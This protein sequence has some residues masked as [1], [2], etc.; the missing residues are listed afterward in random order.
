VI[1]PIKGH[2]RSNKRVLYFPQKSPIS[3]AK[4]SYPSNQRARHVQQKSPQGVL[5]PHNKLC[6]KERSQ[7]P[8]S[9]A[10]K[11]DRSAS[12]GALAAARH[13]SRT[14]G[15]QILTFLGVYFR[16]WCFFPPFYTFFEIGLHSSSPDFSGRLFLRLVFFPLFFHFF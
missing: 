1:S 2:I 5:C 11:E 7:T 14:R 9:S 10:H 3:P 15:P 12:G 4:E 16:G 6:Q 13:R 8:F